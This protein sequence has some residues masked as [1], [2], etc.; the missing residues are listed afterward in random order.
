[1]FE[2]RKKF[3]KNFD[4]V[5]FATV[6]FLCL[7]GLLMISSATASLEATHYIK[8]QLLAMI[9]GIVSIFFFVSIDYKLLGKLYIPIYVLC[10][11]LL[12]AVLVFGT[13]TGAGGKNWG[14]RSWLSIGPITFQPAEIVKVGLIISLSKLI[15][16]NKQNINDPLVLL[17]ILLFAAVPIGL[18]LL[19]PDAGTAAVFVFFVI[20][21]LFAAKLNLRYFGYFLIIII[22]C[23]PIMWFSMKGYQRDRIFSFLDPEHDTSGSGLQGRQAKIAIGSGKIFGRGLYNGVQTQYGYVPEKQT[24]MIFAVVG[25]ELGLLGGLLLFLL[26]FIMLYRL[27]R[28]A[29]RTKDIFGSLMVIGFSAMFTIHIWENIGMNMGLMPITGIPLPF[30]SYGGTFLLVNM[31]CIGISLSVGMKKE[32]LNF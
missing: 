7:Y 14:S 20:V 27:I 26:Y 23:L 28:I 5:L 3:F 16:K 31:I 24:D 22:I 18:I 9:L 15:D 12:V 19:Q 21:M 8:R 4:F 10:N 11:L 32:G 6:I 2:L 1:M 29:R 30:M 25:E 17:K 13:D